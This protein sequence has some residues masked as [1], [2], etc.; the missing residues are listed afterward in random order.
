MA[1]K[2]K[3]SWTC[4]LQ[5]TSNIDDAIFIGNDND[6]PLNLRQLLRCVD[7]SMMEDDMIS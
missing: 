5:K 7:E 6:D 3:A 1:S 2:K 4:K